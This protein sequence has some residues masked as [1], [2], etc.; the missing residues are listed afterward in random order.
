MKT[1]RHTTFPLPII[2]DKPKLLFMSTREWAL[3]YPTT[4]IVLRKQDCNIPLR[5][6]LTQVQKEKAKS[7]RS[8]TPMTPFA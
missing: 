5:K 4:R 2:D 8:M 3:T 6:A 1:L 7:Q